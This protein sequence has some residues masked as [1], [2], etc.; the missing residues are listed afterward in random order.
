MKVAIGP[1]S[2]GAADPKPMEMLQEKGLDVIDNPFKRKLS[3]KEIIEHLQGCT[4]LIAGLEPLNDRVLDACPNL[5]V[6]ARVGIGMDNV[7]QEACAKRGI[8]V[9]NTPDGPTNAVAEFVL[10]A[11]LTIGRN[12]VSGNEALH[13]K[14]WKKQI[15]FSLSGL[16]VL[17][18][19]MGRIGARTAEVLSG[20][21]CVCKGYDPFVSSDFASLEAGLKWA[22]VVT[23]HA[24]GS[25]EIVG[26]DEV[27][28]MNDGVVI[29]N[30]ARGGLINEEALYNGLKDGKIHAAWMDVFPYEPYDGKLTELPNC[31]MTPHTSTY[32]RQC[33]LGMETEAVENLLRDLADV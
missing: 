20:L 27:A 6:I 9:S 23:L 4:G 22:E 30:S 11:L 2:F 12:I 1:S 15:G 8:K 31:I 10:A 3:E 17:V 28:A 16:N 33:R 19:G 21:G 18:V 7:D 14:E 29:L 26:A 32:T 13:R 5:K 24:S 25:D